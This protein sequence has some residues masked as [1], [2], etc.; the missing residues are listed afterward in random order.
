MAAAGYPPKGCARRQGSPDLS[1]RAVALVC[2]PQ[3]RASC[4]L[5]RARLNSGLHLEQLGERSIAARAR[6]PHL[7]RQNSTGFRYLL[8]YFFDF[9]SSPHL[10]AITRPRIQPCGTVFA[11]LYSLVDI[12]GEGC[13]RSLCMKLVATG[14]LEKQS[15]HSSSV[16]LHRE[17]SLIVLES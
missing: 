8:P 11:F 14:V 12:V 5:R 7:R 3:P 1:P 10:R 13:T 2:R 15:F 16:W 4:P 9:A 17:S 6:P